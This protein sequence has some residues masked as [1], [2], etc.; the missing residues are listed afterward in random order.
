MVKSV[1]LVRIVKRKKIRSY[2]LWLH[3]KQGDDFGHVLEKCKGNVPKAL[4]TWAANFKQHAEVCLQLA[5][6]FKGKKI[7]VQADTHMICFDP[8]DVKATAC[9]EALVKKKLLDVQEWDDE[10]ADD[11][12]ED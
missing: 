11:E 12:E 4:K 5:K 8:K 3:Y 2:E 7:T 10:D 6:A 9:L 1:K